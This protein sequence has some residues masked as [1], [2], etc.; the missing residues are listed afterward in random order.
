MPYDYMPSTT[1][2]Y[3]LTS[4]NVMS[5]ANIFTAVEDEQVVSVSTRSTEPNSRVTFTLYKLNDNAKDPT[6]G[7][8]VETQS[9]EIEHKGFHRFDLAEPFK[10][11][12][13]QKFSIVSTVFR[14]NGGARE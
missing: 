2:F 6:D 7:E 8:L 13:G 9:Y 4:K 14:M 11:H 3:E 12:K 1:G 10:I 5:S